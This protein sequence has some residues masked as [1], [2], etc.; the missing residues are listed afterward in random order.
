[1]ITVNVDTGS[2]LESIRQGLGEFA[3]RA[4][5]VL[6]R[7]LNDTAKKAG[8][9]LAQKAKERYTVKNAGFNK[10]IKY[11]NATKSNLSAELKAAGET[12]PV[13][14]F[15]ASPAKPSPSLTGSP[16]VRISVKKSNGMRAVTGRGGAMAFITRFQSGH[17]AV[18]QREP[19]RTY[20]GSGWSARQA[21]WKQ[22]KRQTGKLDRTRIQELY[23][24]S[25]PMMLAKTGVDEG[26]LE[27]MKP[28]IQQYLQ[29]AIEKQIARELHFANSGH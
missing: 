17:V 6:R 7:A 12:I 23:G 28:R 4:P 15:K 29:E 9:E 22:F 11:R 13:S 27:G 14:K 24:P 1:M 20:T 5:D 18:V 10:E 16:A 8:K 26:Y 21:K 19:P 25:V 3:D 2:A